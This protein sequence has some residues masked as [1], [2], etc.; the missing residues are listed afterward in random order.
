MFAMHYSCLPFYSYQV[1]ITFLPC[2]YHV[3]VSCFSFSWHSACY[4]SEQNMNKMRGKYGADSS[5]LVCGIGLWSN[6]Y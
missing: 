1:P 2:S 4:R 6:V 5:M 3:R